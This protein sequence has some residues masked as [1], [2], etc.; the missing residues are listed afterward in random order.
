MSM[1]AAD[2]CRE[3]GWGVGDLIEERYRYRDGGFIQWFY[4]LTA[5]GETEC[6]GVPLGSIHALTFMDKPEEDRA[7]DS[8]MPIHMAE[9]SHFHNGMECGTTWKKIDRLPWEV[10][11]DAA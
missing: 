4:R 7:A 8:E 10:P 1:T 11:D 6:L 5:I 3:R 2:I 9:T